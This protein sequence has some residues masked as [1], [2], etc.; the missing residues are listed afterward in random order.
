MGPGA[1]CE[2]TVARIKVGQMTP[3]SALQPALR[4]LRRSGLRAAELVH[5][6][7]MAEAQ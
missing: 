4:P 7:D 5:S 6:T 3:N 1:R 2:H